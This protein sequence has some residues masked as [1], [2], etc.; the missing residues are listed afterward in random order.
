MLNRIIGKKTSV[1]M[2]RKIYIS[3]RLDKGM[4]AKER[5][6]LS[7]IMGHSPSSQLLIYSKFSK[8]LHKSDD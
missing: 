6:I 3:E 1:Q 2:L 8:D 7:Y 5:K 4:N